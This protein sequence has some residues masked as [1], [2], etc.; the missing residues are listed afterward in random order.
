MWVVLRGQ[1]DLGRKVE[2]LVS[3]RQVGGDWTQ[4][5]DCAK[6]YKRYG[7]ALKAA[8]CFGGF[9]QERL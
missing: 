4:W 3:G 7:A 2:Y 6:V 9:L 8:K 5:A 1:T